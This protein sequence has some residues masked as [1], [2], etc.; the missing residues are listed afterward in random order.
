MGTKIR[1]T[2]ICV[3]LYLFVFCY[4]FSSYFGGCWRRKHHYPKVW[5]RNIFAKTKNHFQNRSHIIF[6]GKN[7]MVEVLIFWIFYFLY[8]LCTPGFIY[9]GFAAPGNRRERNDPTT[10][11]F[12][13]S[14]FF[15]INA[16]RD[17]CKLLLCL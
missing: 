8:L 3:F 4:V 15:F 11:K 5:G 6:G 1:Y 17:R 12:W 2:S 10:F 14:S 9:G 16:C 7:V 13:I